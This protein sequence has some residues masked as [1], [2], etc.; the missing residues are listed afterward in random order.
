MKDR[1]AY[2]IYEAYL[3]EAEGDAV[4]QAFDNTP[5]DSLAM[6][7]NQR[8]QGHPSSV[9]SVFQPPVTI[10]QLRNAEWQTHEHESIRPPAQGFITNIPGIVGVAPIQDPTVP[11][12]VIFQPGHGGQAMSEDGTEVL[13]E[14][15]A[16]L[17]G[18]GIQAQYTTLLIGPSREDENVLVVWTF[19]PGE[20][21]PRLQEITMKQ[22]QEHFNTQETQIKG[23]KE[24]AIGLG[25]VNVKHQ[26]T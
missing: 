11:E 5:E 6:S 10:E 9:G 13:A 12:E 1:D 17:A 4:T 2:L 26:S 18:G 24:D 22:V 15:V 16:N 25:F 8:T 14:V 20:P 23:T 7:L 21:T 19:F 3:K